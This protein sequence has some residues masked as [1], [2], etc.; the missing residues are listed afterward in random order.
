M[1]IRYCCNCLICSGCS[2]YSVLQVQLIV[3]MSYFA[4][5]NMLMSI[6][7]GMQISTRRLVCLKIFSGAMP[8]DELSVGILV[9]L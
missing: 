2:G 4:V 9:M 7:I 1:D 6:F 5:A 8:V 3:S